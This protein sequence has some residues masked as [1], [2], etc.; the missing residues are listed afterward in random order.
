MTT[1]YMDC[2]RVLYVSIYILF[3]CIIMVDV[4][5]YYAYKKYFPYFY[6]VL[7]VLILPFNLW[8]LADLVVETF[9]FKAF[10]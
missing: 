6:M 9:Y 8:S 1:H 5:F 7:L 3:T 4:S 2:F 10:G